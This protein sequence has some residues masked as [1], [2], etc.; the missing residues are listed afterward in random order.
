MPDLWPWLTVLRKE[1]AR[2]AQGEAESPNAVHQ[3]GRSAGYRLR[4]S[5]VLRGVPE[6]DTRLTRPR[7]GRDCRSCKRN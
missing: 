7:E 1:N 2:K 3:R 5:T 4:R 6:P